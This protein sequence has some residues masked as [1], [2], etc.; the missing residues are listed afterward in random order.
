MVASCRPV[1]CNT[2]VQTAGGSGYA[3]HLVEDHPASVNLRRPL[4]QLE[5]VQIPLG[6]ALRVIHGLDVWRV[7]GVQEAGVERVNGEEETRQVMRGAY[8]RITPWC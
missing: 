2:A 4:R 7:V 5:V 1:K 8:T 6:Q 3:P